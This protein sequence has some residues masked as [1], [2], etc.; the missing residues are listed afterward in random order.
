MAQPE[1]VL[2]IADLHIPYHDK[3]AVKLMLKAA[4]DL[5]PKYILINGDF[6][7][8]YSV[9]SHSKDPRRSLKLR[10]EVDTALEVLDRIDDLG[11]KHKIFIG[12]NHCDRL[13]RYLQ[14]KAPELFDFIDI[15]G[16]LELKKRNW[17]YVPY[18]HDAKIGKLWFTHDVGVAG[19]NAM[20]KALDTYQHSIIT[21]HTHRLNYVVEGNATGEVKLSAQFGWLGDAKSVDYMQRQTVLKNWALGFGVGYLEPSTGNVYM[22]PVP[23]FGGYSCCVNGR[24]YRG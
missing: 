24:I 12:G 22:T 14:D 21:G 13:E 9:S 4:A 3:R 23:I 16:I 1:P 15:P 8:C 5:K 10:Q 20:F 19:R 18:K 6:L 17:A 2:V 11:A 7:D